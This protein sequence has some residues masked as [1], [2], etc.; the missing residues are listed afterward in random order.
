MAFFVT[1]ASIFLYITVGPPADPPEPIDVNFE[2]A[3]LSLF[4]LNGFVTGATF[5]VRQR[6][7]RRCL[8]A[9]VPRRP[10]SSRRPFGRT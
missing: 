9:H 7:C 3:T 1:L 6:R 8:E 2:D 10:L 5:I 4:A